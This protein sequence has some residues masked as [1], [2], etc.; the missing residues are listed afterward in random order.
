[1]KKDYSD[2]CTLGE[3]MNV[4]VPYGHQLVKQTVK[5]PRTALVMTSNRPG[6]WKGPINDSGLAGHTCAEIATQLGIRQV[7][8]CVPIVDLAKIEPHNVGQARSNA[9]VKVL[10]GKKKPR[11]GAR[12]DHPGMI[13]DVKRNGKRTFGR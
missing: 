8:A 3:L 4:A 10:S 11:K 9:G 2:T 1:M 6:D 12:G 7:K 13:S 5:L